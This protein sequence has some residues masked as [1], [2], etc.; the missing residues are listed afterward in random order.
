[1]FSQSV[2]P[3]TPDGAKRSGPAH[4]KSTTTAGRIAP[5]VAAALLAAALSPLA[6][7]PA[8]AQ[9][10]GMGPVDPANGFPTW[11]SDGTVRL[12][13]CYQAGQ[14]CLVEPPNPGQPASYP[15]NFPDEAFW[16][17]AEASSGNLGLYEAALEAAH[18][19][20]AVADGD[21]M[22]FARLRFRL[23]GLQANA[24]YTITHPYGVHIFTADGFGEINETLDQGACAPTPDAAC[25]WAGV[26]AAFLGDFG[27]GT[28]ATFLRQDGAAPGTL[29]DI[30]TARTVTGAPSGN[31]FVNVVGPNAGGP[32]INTLTVNTFTVQ[33]LIATDSVGG[34]N[35]PDLPA[36]SDSG[37]SSTDNITK[38]NAP[39]I[40]GTLPAGTAGPVQLVVDN[41]APRA[42]TLTG[43]TYSLKLAPLAHGPHTVRAV[44]G[45]QS[46]RHPRVHGGHGCA[47]GLDSGTVPVL[48]D[49][50]HHPGPE[51]QEQ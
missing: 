3:K 6:V 46:S 24:S 20:D 22:G 37:R 42:A 2:R 9:T 36:A 14:G 48:A 7:A 23:D 33:G 27:R 19:N 26:G 13:L 41:G 34:P 35:T 47:A 45:G 11:F 8:N 12:Q 38:V 17:A 51:L 10:A 43:S 32:G 1:M 25:N 31:N 4:R 16:F 44:A 18:A 39:T 28:T 49:P 50:G 40:T 30:N 29:G 15:D 5:A 21:Q